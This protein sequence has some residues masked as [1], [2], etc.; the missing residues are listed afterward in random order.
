[1]NENAANACL[2]MIEDVEDSQFFL[3]YKPLTEWDA[4]PGWKDTFLL[5]NLGMEHMTQPAWFGRVC[6]I[7][8][9]LSFWGSRQHFILGRGLKI[10]HIFSYLSSARKM[11]QPGP[12]NR[13]AAWWFG[14]LVL[15]VGRV[16]SAKCW[17]VNISNFT[18]GMTILCGMGQRHS[19]APSA[20]NNPESWLMSKKRQYL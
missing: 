14:A 7:S 3:G 5:W 6:H 15:W 9:P 19:K 1:M 11:I 13:K 16:K 2:K 18:C 12:P 17:R 4:H 10:F 8:H 20:D